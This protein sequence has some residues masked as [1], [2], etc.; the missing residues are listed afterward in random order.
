LAGSPG[1]WRRLKWFIVY[2]LELLLD[3]HTSCERVPHQIQLI[4]YHG[5]IIIWLLYRH[6][7]DCSWRYNA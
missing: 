3:R 6:R 1:L 5:G 7:R 2:L 4:A